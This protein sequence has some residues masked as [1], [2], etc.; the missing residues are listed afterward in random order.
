MSLQQPISQPGDY[1][2]DQRLSS[3]RLLVG[4]LHTMNRV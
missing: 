2:E 1:N 3:L 4:R